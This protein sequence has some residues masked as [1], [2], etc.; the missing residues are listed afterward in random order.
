MGRRAKAEVSVVAFMAFEWVKL[1]DQ[2]E[3]VT[4]AAWA[5]CLAKVAAAARVEMPMRTATAAMVRRREKFIRSGFHRLDARLGG[6]CA[7]SGNLFRRRNTGMK[8]PRQGCCRGFEIR[9]GWISCRPDWGRSRCRRRWGW[10]EG[11]VRLAQHRRPCLDCRACRSCSGAPWHQ[12][13][14]P[15]RQ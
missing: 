8:K 11:C 4:T 2:R 3:A 15:C 1:R 9:D 12:G 5:R 6:T 7:E 13:Y 14:E 10:G